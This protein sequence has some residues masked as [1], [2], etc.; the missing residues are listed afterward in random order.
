MNLAGNKVC[1]W[2]TVTFFWLQNKRQNKGWTSWLNTDDSDKHYQEMPDGII[3]TGN[4]YVT[5]QLICYDE[6]QWKRQL[7]ATWGN[8]VK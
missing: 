7:Q 1:T 6:T 8:S 4:S 3:L 5:F 2:Q